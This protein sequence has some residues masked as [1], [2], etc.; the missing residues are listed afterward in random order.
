MKILIAVDGSVPSL[1]AV[2]AFA[3]RASWFRATP[4]ITLLH[5]QP[6]IPYK[7]AAAFAGR[8]AVASYYA[9]ESDAALEGAVKLLQGGGIAFAIEKCVGEPADEIVSRAEAGAFDL[10]VMGT[11]GHTA[12]ANLVMGSVASKVLARSKVPV[13]FMKR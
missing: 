5:A 12:L 7:A 4:E 3:E 13:L 10:I 8:E 1:A 9:Q 6:P 11:H 2:T